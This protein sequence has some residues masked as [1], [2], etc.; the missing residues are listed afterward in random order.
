MFLR[1]LALYL[2]LIVICLFILNQVARADTIYVSQYGSDTNDG[3]SDSPYL[4]IQHSVN[5]AV[6][7]DYIYVD[8]GV[9]SETV[10]IGSSNI[11]LEGAGE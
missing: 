2:I 5:Q 9:Y 7:G 8:T 3:T 1:R 4:T 11:T 10:H 6:S